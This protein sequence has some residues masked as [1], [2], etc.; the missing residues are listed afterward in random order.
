M[1]LWL[2]VAADGL[3]MLSYYSIPLALLWFMRRRRDVPHRW[4]GFLFVAFIVACGST[5]LFSIFTIWVPV[6]GM[7]AAVKLLTAGL[8]IAT[9]CVLWPLI[10][11]V[12]EVP[13]VAQ[14]AAA[15]RELA[16]VNEEL[17]AFSYS[18]SHDL[19]SPLRAINGYAR[20]L[21]DDFAADLPEA[22]RAYLA[23]VI[24]NTRR[25]GA[26]I[27]ALLSFARLARMPIAREPIDIANLAQDIIAELE[28]AFAGRRIEFSVAEMP[29]VHGDPAL[30]RQVLQNLIDNAIKYSRV[31]PLARIEIGVQSGNAAEGGADNETIFTVTDNG[32]G[33]DMAYADRLFGVF[34]RLHRAEEYE[35]AGVG[36]ATAQRIVHRH[37][38]RIWAEAAPDRGATFCFT[39]APAAA[40]R[41]AQY[42]NGA[43]AHAN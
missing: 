17:E 33:F 32:V 19:R 3:T 18:V 8:S 39:L 23:V 15:N 10:P 27:D 40:A 6:Y 35:G 11:R 28:P 36:L 20:I 12:L 21:L 16:F 34:Q 25:M 31:R 37:G 9:A 24:A 43:T 26:L 1:L 38:G 30:V 13:S 5:H 29:P 2:S 41:S 7:E 42:P 14:M 22:A 4:V